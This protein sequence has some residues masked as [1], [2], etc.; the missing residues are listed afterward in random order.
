VSPYLQYRNID[1]PIFEVINQ[2]STDLGAELRYE[3]TAPLAGRENRFTLGFQP[4][5]ERMH[6]RQFENQ[7]G[8]HGALTRD[9][10]DRATTLAIYMEDAFSVTPRLAAT[11]GVRFDRMTRD[12]DDDFLSNGDQSDARTYQPV[13]PRF[14]LLYSLPG[15]GQLFAN[16]SRTVE[17]PLFL[18]LSSFGN[19]GGFIDLDAQAAWQYEVGARAESK[20]VTWEIS[21]Y[22]IELRDEILNINV[23]PFP[24]A[25]FTVP[26]FRNAP[27]T[28]HSGVEIGAAY[29]LPGGVF[30]GGDVRDHLTARVAYTFGRYEY[31]EDSTYAG[32]DIPG[33]PR[34]YLTAELQYVHPSGF[35]L[36]PTIE[37]VPQSYYVN[38]ANT[39]K[40]QA[41]SNF[42]FRAAWAI[43]RL[44]AT[45]FVSGQNLADRRFAQSVQ[46]D[47]A[48]GKYFEP[49]DGRS[50]SAGLR[51]SR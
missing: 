39:V 43:E 51:W 2:Q 19:E 15:G 1:H 18:E 31:V 24:D 7:A 45:A 10:Q 32:N 14:G 34:H 12:V 30:V 25:P 11:A 17:P 9:E 42:G 21:L 6:N 20:G 46:V 38:S 13:T 37:W 48:A 8:E 26:T 5:W 27:R 29:Q 36:A 44:G 40:N 47:N 35:S 16:A 50:F 28:R 41:W 49:A 3:N 22:D 4:A 23:Q 33:A